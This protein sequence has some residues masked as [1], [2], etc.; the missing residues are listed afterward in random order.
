MAAPAKAHW[1]T[2]RDTRDR[3]MPR[4]GHIRRDRTDLG[5]ELLSIAAKPGQELTLYD[6][7]AWCG[8]TNEAVRRIYA[9]AL[10]K[11]TNRVRFGRHSTLARELA[12]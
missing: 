4:S 11:V 8:C 6:I 7:A 3:N 1:K 9:R 12:A 10:R 5:L 2:D